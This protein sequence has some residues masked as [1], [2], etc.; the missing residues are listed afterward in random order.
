MQIG[1]KC[2]WQESNLRNVPARQGVIQFR[3]D[4]PP[5]AYN[6]AR[7]MVRFGGNEFSF[8][9]ASVPLVFEKVSYGRDLGVHWVAFREGG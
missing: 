4:H 7:G 6:P 8:A 9:Q 2:A 1:G 5:R 3:P